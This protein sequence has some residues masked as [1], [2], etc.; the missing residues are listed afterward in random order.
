VSHCATKT[1]QALRIFVNNELN[2]LDAGLRGAHL[3]LRRAGLCV[4]VSFHSLEDRIVKRHFHAI[5]LDAKAN[6]SVTPLHRDPG[7][8]HSPD[9]IGRLMR[10]RWRPVCRTVATPGAAEVAANPRARSAK[11]RAA[12]KL[13]D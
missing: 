8:T 9:Y 4:A 11:L 7:V 13:A 2:E 12:W 10:T 6:L 1:F 3:L 5:D